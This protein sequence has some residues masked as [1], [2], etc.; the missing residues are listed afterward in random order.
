MQRHFSLSLVYTQRLL[1]SLVGPWL[2]GWEFEG[3]FLSH[4][5]CLSTWS[6]L[7]YTAGWFYMLSPGVK[8]HF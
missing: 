8:G 2:E 6:L 5:T 4:A 1:K 3:W 7:E